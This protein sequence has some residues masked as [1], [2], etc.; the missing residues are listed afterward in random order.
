MK[1]KLLM[2][3]SSLVLVFGLAVLVSCSDEIT[4]VYNPANDGAINPIIAAQLKAEIVDLYR[5]DAS[6]TAA[7]NRTRKMQAFIME[8][9]LHAKTRNPEFKIIPQDGINLA[10]EDGDWAKGAKK[11][12]ISLVDGW[13]IEGVVGYANP[14]PNNDNQKKYNLLTQYGLMVTDTTSVTT[15]ERLQYYYDNAAALNIIPYPRVGGSLVIDTLYPGKR[16]ATNSDYFW[17]EDPV[18]IGIGDRIH[19]G[20]V[21]KLTDA[22]NY[23]Y[24]INGRPFDDWASWDAEEEAAIDEGEEDRSRIT[25]GY[26]SGLLVPTTPGNGKYTPVGTSNTVNTA[27]ATYGDQWDWWWRVAGYNANQGREV[28][29]NTL[30]NSNYDVI[31]IDSFY[32]HRALPENQTPLTKAEVD[33]LKTKKNG[34]RRQI[35]A[36]LSIGSAEQNRW[37]CQD[38][39]TYTD[40][41]PNSPRL[42]KSGYVSGGVYV[43]PPPEVPGWLADNYGGSYEEE[44]IVA[45]WHPEWRD[46]IVRGNSVYQHKTTGDNTS[47][48]DR[49]I[50][51]GFD[52]VYLDNVGVYNRSRWTQFD[53]YWN[54]NGGFPLN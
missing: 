54:S 3:I 15:P 10:F 44:A 39:W 43:P 38:D 22:K 31:Y 18:T 53:T 19:S 11:S 1:N 24:H 47:S 7:I 2:G 28:W 50:N 9:A 37:Y 8:I 12:L 17:I 25:D 32:N 52:G 27:I 20:N 29:L 5:D 14:L 51:Q 36:Y 33:S 45:W 16:W 6:A 46:I 26:A 13:G 21:Y 34:G 30:R 48:I 35:I 42:M 23:L 49:I 4:N 41:Y 40:I